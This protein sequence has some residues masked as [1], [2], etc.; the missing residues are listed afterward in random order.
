MNINT[1]ALYTGPFTVASNL[2]LADNASTTV[3][4]KTVTVQLASGSDARNALNLSNTPD[5]LG[6]T[7]F[8]QEVCTSIRHRAQPY[9]NGESV[10]ND[11]RA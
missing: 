8:V 9:A 10:M 6:K 5:N 4:D 2:L 1:G 11:L 3:V 7:V